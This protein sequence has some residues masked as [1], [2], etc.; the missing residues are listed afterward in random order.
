MVTERYLGKVLLMISRE[1]ALC[2]AKDTNLIGMKS[3]MLLD[4]RYG[5]QSDSTW[6]RFFSQ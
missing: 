5:T 2:I 4:G 3:F 6:F 1:F